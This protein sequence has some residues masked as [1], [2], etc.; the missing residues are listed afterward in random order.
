LQREGEH[1]YCGDKLDLTSGFS[2]DP[3]HFI[4][5]NIKCKNYGWKDMSIPNSVYFMLNIVKDMAYTI[6]EEKKQVLYTV[7]FR[8]LYI[9]M[10]DTDVQGVQ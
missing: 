10:Q 7:I 6:K 2:Y 4:C 5:E 1:P 9:V 3:Q 8:L